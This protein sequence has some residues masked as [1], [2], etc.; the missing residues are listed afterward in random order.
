MPDELIK[1]SISNGISKINIDT[2]LKSSWNRAVRNFIE[3]NK[4]EYDPRKIIGSGEKAIKEVI[5][6]KVTLFGSRNRV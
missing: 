5:N 6:K 1:K 2:E 3:N 4:E